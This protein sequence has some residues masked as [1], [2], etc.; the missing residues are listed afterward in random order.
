[1]TQP[2]GGEAAHEALGV[3]R[4]LGEGLVQG[5]I[6]LRMPPHELENLGGGEG[7]PDGVVGSPHEHEEGGRRDPRRPSGEGGLEEVG[8]EGIG[9]FGLEGDGDHLGPGP[10][11][12]A[13]IAG[14]SPA[15]RRGPASRPM[16]SGGR[17]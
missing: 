1:M 9:R 17:R 4:K 5:E 13:E 14:I 15:R 2:R 16:P 12:G 11:G 3:A 10:L 6:D 7:T 8:V